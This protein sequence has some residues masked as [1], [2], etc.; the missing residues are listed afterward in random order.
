MKINA[1]MA[2][3]TDKGYILFV[4]DRDDINKFI[5]HLFTIDNEYVFSSSDYN[6]VCEL[7]ESL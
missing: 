2:N 1:R 7:L 5:Y 3:L 4:G 6:E